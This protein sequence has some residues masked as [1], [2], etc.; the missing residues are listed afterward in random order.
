LLHGCSEAARN[1]PAT[2]DSLFARLRSERIGERELAYWR[3]AQCDPEGANRARYHAGD[4]EA[5]RERAIVEWRKRIPEGKLPP[6]R[7]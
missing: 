1:D 2:Y 5:Q 4:P 3:L 6:G 7:F